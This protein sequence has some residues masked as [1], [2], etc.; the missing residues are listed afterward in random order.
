MRLVIAWYDFW[1]GAFY[2]CKNRRLFVFPVPCIG[3]CIESAAR[4]DRAMS[5]LP[6]ELHED[7][8]R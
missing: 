2:D 7:V 3:L 1:I 4:A 6:A 5:L 8:Q